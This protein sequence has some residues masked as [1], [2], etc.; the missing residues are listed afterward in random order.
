MRGLVNEYARHNLRFNT[1]RP[2]VVDT[3]N[4]RGRYTEQEW[5]NYIGKMPMRRAGTVTENAN[6][7]VVLSDK[8]LSGFING[9]CLDVDGARVHH[10]RP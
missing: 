3:P 4:N 6:M 9:T 10:L 2:A 1:V 8:N 7:I 5:L